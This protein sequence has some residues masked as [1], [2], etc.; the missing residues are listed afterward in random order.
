[1]QLKI[2]HVM[3]VPAHPICALQVKRVVNAPS[4]KK[5]LLQVVVVEPPQRMPK[6]Q[7]I[8]VVPPK[9]Q[10]APPSQ[11]IIVA[12]RQPEA[13][14]QVL[15]VGPQLHREPLPQVIDMDRPQ[16]WPMLHVINVLFLEPL[17]SV[18]ESNVEQKAVYVG[19]NNQQQV[20][21]VL[22]FL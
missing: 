7:V 13:E 9:L 20:D 17:I 14:L 3:K 6:L 12:P 4:Q 15:C 2:P 22:G 10:P 8:K 21:A 11:V 16:K 5:P 19:S 18:E 1:M